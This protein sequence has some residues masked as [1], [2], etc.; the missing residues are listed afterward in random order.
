MEHHR[1]QQALPEIEQASVQALE[2]QLQPTMAI[3]Y[4]PEV[5]TRGLSPS[6]G[7]PGD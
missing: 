7:K 3:Q 6:I 1:R 2:K 4:R 5:L